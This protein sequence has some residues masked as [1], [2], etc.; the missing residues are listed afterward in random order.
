MDS[1]FESSVFINC[2][3]DDRYLKL[4]RPLLFTVSNLGFTPRIASER[5]DSLENRLDK[6]CQLIRSCRYSIHDLSRLRSSTAGEF[7]RM[8]MP[9]ELGIDYGCRL[10]GGTPLPDKKCL[11]LEKE[12]YDFRRAISDLAGVDIKAHKNEA[13]SVVRAVRDWFLETVGVRGIAAPSVIWYSF[14]DFATDFY[15]QRK[16]DGYS[17]EDLNMMPVAEYIEFIRRWLD[18]EEA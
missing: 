18:S 12:P 13:V 8:N 3:F 15:T 5:S 16:I 7:S 9:F 2:P 6:I 1:E 4:L 14:S 17:D 10:Y 11:I